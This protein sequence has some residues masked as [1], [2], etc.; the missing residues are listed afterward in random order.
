LRVAKLVL[1][2]I[3]LA[4]A[5][6]LIPVLWLGLSQGGKGLDAYTI[7][8]LMFT[9]WQSALSTVL[10]L[11]LGVPAAIALARRT[12]WGR[13][14]LVSLLALPMALPQIV[15]VLGLIGLFGAEG[16][17]AG[18]WPLYGLTGI[19]LAHVFFNAALVARMTLTALQS[20]PAEQLRV[21]SQLNLTDL[22]HL[23]FIDAPALRKSLPGTA[24]I[25]FLLCAASFTIV[26]TLGGGPQGTTLEVALYQA[27]RTDFDPARAT[28]LALLQ[29]ALCF[30]LGFAVMRFS[31]QANQQPLLRISMS[32][33]DGQSAGAALSDAIALGLLAFLLVLPLLVLLTQGVLA[34]AFTSSFF[35]ALSTSLSFALI[36]SIVTCAMAYGLAHAAARNS[37]YLM[38]G[39]IASIAGLALPP[40]AIA[41]G[42]FIL[43]S[44]TT[45]TATIAPVLIVALNS[46]VTLPYAYGLLLPKLRSLAEQDRLAASLGLQGLT[47]LRIDLRAM[48]KPLILSLAMT[49]VISFGD[50]AAVLF[51]GDGRYVTLPALIYQ[52]MGSYRMEGA[53][54]TAVVLALMSWA[55]LFCAE[56]VTKDA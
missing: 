43:A 25:V 3:T 15:V 8:I 35:R 42:W 48:R 5:A 36:T 54:G 20:I 37:R 11:L 21:A 38:A 18:L 40:A 27:L 9:L 50:L 17:L 28:T 16:W 33:Y 46:L 53:M 23:R 56:K 26:L 39:Q 6:G 32:R 22:Q 24:L 45:G 4:L 44:S 52:Q 47:R 1:F 19:L 29:V 34:L 30:A 31:S 49:A 10:S 41:T 13:S 12:F 2:A 14:A 51:F 7:R 55:V